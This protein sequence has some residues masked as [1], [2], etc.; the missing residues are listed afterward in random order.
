MPP[1][2]VVTR[3]SRVGVEKWTNLDFENELQRRQVIGNGD[4]DPPVVQG[5][6]R[7][8]ATGY[9]RGL[10]HR[11]FNGVPVAR[12]LLNHVGVVFRGATN[13]SRFDPKSAGAM[14]ERAED[15]RQDDKDII[16]QRR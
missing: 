4:A 2:S 1:A 15:L 11:N 5:A 9:A 6:V 16:G 8:E 13:N 14:S 7:R 3:G 12:V 10:E